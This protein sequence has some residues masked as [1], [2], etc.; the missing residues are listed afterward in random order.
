MIE[1]KTQAMMLAAL[2]C[3][4]PG[5]CPA[6]AKAELLTIKPSN[7]TRV[8]QTY[9]DQS[10]GT[11]P[12]LR[13]DTTPDVR[14]LM[15]F[16]VA[17]VNGRTIRSVTLKLY[18]ID[19]TDKGGDLYKLTTNN[20]GELSTTYNTMPAFDTTML[21]S[22]G[23]ATAGG[24]ISAPVT[25][26]ITIDANYSIGIKGASGDGSIYASKEYSSG[27]YAPYLEIDLEPVATPTPVP[28]ATPVPSPTASP[29]PYAVADLGYTSVL[30]D[31]VLVNGTSCSVQRDKDSG[32]IERAV[33]ISSGG[34][35]FRFEVRSGDRWTNDGTDKNRSEIEH[36]TDHSYGTN[37]WNSH[38]FMIEPGSMMTST[39]NVMGQWHNHGGTPPLFFTLKGSDK[40][41]ISTRS[42]TSSNQL[43][44]RDVDP[45]NTLD[46]W[47]EG[48]I[49]RGVWH[50]LVQNV[51]FG[52]N[53]N[54]HLKIWLD[55]NLI[56]D[57]HNISM[58]YSDK[59]TTYWKFGLYR[60]S[61][62][63]TTVVHYA[64][65]ETGTIDLSDRI[66]HP[67]AIKP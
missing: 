57:Q 2:L 31:S 40:F 8:N 50:N 12:E 62:S 54:A 29:T 36:P 45:D 49:S 41:F 61:S 28:T 17:G 58:G 23:A 13:T 19:P 33:K 67:L 38:S 22:F 56:V 4:L 34:R 55:G 3:N 20:W 9:A 43:S 18:V 47:Y 53:N 30:S 1:K 24:W 65:M 6:T 25:G 11:D 10:F 42:G 5:L 51:V 35:A 26:L 15:K 46:G 48:T 27:A 7:D 32:V 59:T 52:A 16:P 21:G 39:W 60:N 44:P 66:A 37:L 64:N 14:T 63:I